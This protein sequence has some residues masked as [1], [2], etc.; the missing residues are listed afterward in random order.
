MSEHDLTR[1]D[2][3]RHSAVAGGAAVASASH[4]QAEPETRTDA[5]ATSYH[6][7]NVLFIMT[8]QQRFDCLAA[9]GNPIIQT[10]NLD[11]LAARSANFQRAYVQSPVCVPSRGCYFT[12]L[13]AHSHRNRVNY[14]AMPRGEVFLQQY[15]RDA[16]YETGCVG[17]LHLYPPTA[18]EA[19]R[20]GFRHI[21]LHDGIGRTDPHSDYVR[22]RNE[23]DPQ[24]EIPYRS[25][26]RNVPA[27]KNPFRAAIDDQF[28]DTTWC[29]LKTRDLLA[30][31]AGQEKPF[32]VFTSFWKPHSPYEVPVP[33]DSM[34]DDVQIPLP[35][36]WT[37]EE[38]RTKPL[39]I[40]KQILRF[41]PK[42]D[43]NRDLLQWI[44]RSYYASITHIDREVGLI[45]KTLEELQ[46]ARKTLV[47]F[48]SD[49][50]DQLLE[51]GLLGKNVLYEASVRVPL[52]LSAPGAVTPGRY[53]Q[54]VESVD[55]IP[56]LFDLLGLEIPKHVQGRSFAGLISPGREKY[57]TKDAIF[58][59]NIIPEVITRP[60]NM[61]YQFQKGH[62][63][64]GIRYPDAK[65]IRTD[66]WKFCYYPE[67]YGELFDVINDPAE[68]HN[69]FD[70]PKHRET[71][72]ALKGR[73]LDWM[74]T[75][76]DTRQ[77][78]EKW[79]L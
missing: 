34:Y 51:H 27:G 21:D 67:G 65:M 40:Q 30:K 46:P 35:R 48:A 61:T 45:L 26:A 41:T 75:A 57:T 39:P 15:L 55:L 50:G 76:D 4:A 60:S 72:I 79:L 64:A 66:K 70:D 28:T 23:R 31:L 74:I 3:I 29:G 78:A 73:L 22:W 59:E 9:N 33:F 69:L 37:V 71:I 16:G 77:I 63:I 58:C 6:G 11:R 2:F 10:L 32:F 13:Y 7:A 19:R 18:A 8:D 1:R 14:T 49:H 38:I 25:Y 24:K 47:I 44:Y 54:P 68:E 36:Q 17:K 56:S 42:Y 53:D 12:G 52:L 43:M 62:G 20:T 5:S